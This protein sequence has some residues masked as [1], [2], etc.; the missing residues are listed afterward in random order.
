MSQG[1][2]RGLPSVLPPRT[3]RT[4]RLEFLRRRN[5]GLVYIPQRS[6]RP[7]IASWWRTLTGIAPK[8]DP[9]DAT[10]ERLTYEVKS[11]EP[12]VFFRVAV[13]LP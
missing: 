5:S 8:I 11:N 10:W 2:V 12:N 4:F 3:D 1:G 7:D 9:I 13:R 6:T